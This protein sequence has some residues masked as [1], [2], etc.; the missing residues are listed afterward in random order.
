[1]TEFRPN[2]TIL[3]EANP[4]YRDPA[5]PAFATVTFKGGGDAVAAARAVLVTGAFD[6]A[7]NLQLAPEVLRGMRAAGR[8]T[9][10]S[11]FGTVVER[12]VV[13]LTDPSPERG[14]ARSTRAHPHPFLTDRAVRRALSMAIDR[15]RLV[16]TGLRRG[17]TADVQRGSGSGDLRVHGE[18]RLPRTGHRGREAPAGRGRVAARPGRRQATGRRAALRPVPDLD[19]RGRQA[20]QALIGQW[21]SEIGVATELRDIDASVFF[22]GDPGSP[23]TYQKFFADIEMY[24]SGFEGADP[25]SHLGAFRCDNEPRPASRW[26]GGNVPRYCSDAY[27]RLLARMAVTG[28]VPERARIGRAL[29]DMLVQ[30]HV[31]I[32]LVHRGRVSAHARS[33]GGVRLN[34]WDSQIWN[35]ADWHRSG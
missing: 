16:V 33:L 14:G 13:N 1:M 3:L 7:S 31:L 32:P 12:L 29:N 17:R 23:D 30:D 24:A 21:W 15:K 22:G 4:H 9:V 26:R 6:Y 20:F 8:G 25:E 11:G 34:T 27:D 10:V 18:R 2:G 28:D 5:K 19:Q 35:I